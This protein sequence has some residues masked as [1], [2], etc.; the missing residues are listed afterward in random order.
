MVAE[1][2]LGA[3]VLD[4]T[5]AGGAYDPVTRTGSTTNGAGTAWTYKNPGTHPQGIRQVGVKTNRLP[6]FV[7]VK[8][9]GT[10]GTYPVMR[11]SGRRR[12]G[13]VQVG[14]DKQ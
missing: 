3:A 5:I 2:A 11:V 9:K 1:D 12:R 6:G 7:K 4:A 14:D 10:N 13:A 8:I